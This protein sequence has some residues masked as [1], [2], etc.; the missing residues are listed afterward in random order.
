M[1]DVRVVQ[2][3]LEAARLALRAA[4]KSAARAGSEGQAADDESPSSSS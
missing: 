1:Q 2:R 3:A 4:S